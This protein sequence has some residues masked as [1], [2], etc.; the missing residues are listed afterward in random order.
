MELFIQWSNAIEHRIETKQYT[1]AAFYV[2]GVVAISCAVL[3]VVAKLLSLLPIWL[4]LF[5]VFGGFFYVVRWSMKR[6]GEQRYPN[7]EGDS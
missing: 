6:H 1:V 5:T 3:I 4:V 7:E 2:M